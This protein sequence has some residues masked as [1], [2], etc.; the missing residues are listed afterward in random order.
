MGTELMGAFFE[1]ARRGSVLIFATGNDG[2]ANP[3]IPSGLPYL[4]PELK[5]N[6]I[7]VT[8]VDKTLRWAPNAD[9]CGVSAMWCIAAPGEV[10]YSTIPTNEYKNLNGTSMAAPHVTGA[11][12]IAKQMFPNAS[13]AELASIVLRTAVDIGDPGIDDIYG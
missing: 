12:A 4:F 10:I 7:D 9:A 11:V 6:W 8:S 2:A 3:G 5:N 1:S 13:G